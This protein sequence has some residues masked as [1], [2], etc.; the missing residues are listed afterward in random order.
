MKK[1]KEV[2]FL[3]V[4]SYKIEENT[5]RKGNYCFYKKKQHL[6]IEMLFLVLIPNVYWESFKG[7]V[8]ILCLLS[9]IKE[10]IFYM[11]A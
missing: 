6:L 9:L 7:V 10:N 2:T 4:H 5:N 8:S 3:S 11:H 1:T